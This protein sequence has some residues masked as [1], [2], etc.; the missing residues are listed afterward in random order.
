MEPSNYLKPL[1]LEKD[2]K[3][4]QTL[5]G[6]CLLNNTMHNAAMANFFAY[7]GL[8]WLIR[9]KEEL[10]S[11]RDQLLTKWEQTVARLSE[12]EAKAAEVVV[13]ETCLQQSEQEVVTLSQ[14]IGPLRVKFDE[15]NAK[16]DEVHNAVLAATDRE[17][18]FPERL[19]NLEAALNFKT[20]EL[21]AAGVKY[22][23]GEHEEK[24]LEEAKMGIIEFDVEIAKARE[25]ELAAKKGLLAEADA[26]GSETSGT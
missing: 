7:E 9:E 25:L 4:I 22:A 24:I 15:A 26:S 5:S 11:A 12:L 21:A 23:G 1:A 2:W 19:T 13:L 14:E 10:T 17:A 16:W 6:E 3:K 20:E 8:Q 18:A